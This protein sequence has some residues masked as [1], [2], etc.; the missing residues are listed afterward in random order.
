MMTLE[1]V[2]KD[3][4]LR[5]MKIQKLT[6]ELKK[7]ELNLTLL[8]EVKPLLSVKERAVKQLNQEWVQAVHEIKKE[9][10]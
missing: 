2:K 7:E 4:S 8:L 6:N 9:Q 3:I 10:K 1:E 5:R